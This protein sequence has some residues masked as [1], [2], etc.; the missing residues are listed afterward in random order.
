MRTDSLQGAAS[1]S[2][3]LRMLCL[4]ACGAESGVRTAAPVLLMHLYAYFLNVAVCVCE[5]VCVCMCVLLQVKE[6][7]VC[8][9][10]PFVYPK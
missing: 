8:F 10:M 5:H 2:I 3:A 6:L 4:F 1:S 7:F 9:L